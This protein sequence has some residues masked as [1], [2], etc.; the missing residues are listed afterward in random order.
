MAAQHW[1]VGGH[2]FDGTGAARLRADVL[3]TDG[4]ITAV[5][6]VDPSS[7]PADRA[8]RD[9]ARVTDV[10]GS[11]LLPGFIDAH[12]HVGI[13]RLHGQAALPPAV[14]AATIFAIL[15]S[16]LRQGF[17]T[18]RDLGGVDGGLVQAITD[19]LVPGPR[20]L[21][22]GQILSQTGGHG[23]MRGH[24]S[25][26]AAN[27]GTGA[28]GLALAMRLVD[29][30]DE[31]RKA[32]RDQFRRGATQLKVFATGGLLSHGDPVDCPQLSVDE[33]RAAVEIAEDRNS[34]VTAHAHTPRGLLR[35]VRAGARCIE[36]ASHIDAET[37]EAIVE[38]DVA[39]IGTLTMQELL[40][41]DPETWGLDA[42]RREEAARLRD[43]T[44]QSMTMLREA[45]VRVGGGAD[46]VGETQ[47]LRAWE[48]ALHARL[49]GGSAGIQTVTRVNAEILG[50]DAEVGTIEPGKVADLV[51]WGGD[52]VTYPE[53]LKDNAPTLVVLGG[54][55]VA[56]PGS[57]EEEAL[58]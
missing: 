39:V 50:I 25:D 49:F 20:L 30:V 22:S 37:L 17:T 47:D 53:L 36:H 9:G 8:G 7:R 16:S 1:F 57:G 29:G 34:Y 56:G 11:T 26:E 46:L 41:V 44:V 19:G 54:R 52:P 58:G 3:V 23:D 4:R 55:T 18:L 28:T 43:L 27:P 13:L 2:V 5:E 12:A 31:M 45:G 42:S 21:P 35:A 48:P 51:A 32:A 24:Y 10:S 15:K 33:I 40:R 38:N 6:P 14:Q